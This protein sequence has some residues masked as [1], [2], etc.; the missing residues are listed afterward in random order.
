MMR[1][2][3]FGGTFNP[4]HHGHLR[5]ALEVKEGFPLDVCYLIPSAVPPHKRDQRV[6]SAADRMEMIRLAI[7]GFEGFTLCDVE[8]QRS[9]PSY[10]VDTVADLKNNLPEYTELFLMLGLDAFLEIDTWKQYRKLL[11]EIP[12]IVMIRPDTGADR[13]TDPTRRVAQYLHRHIS[14]DYKASLSPKRFTHH[15]LQTVFTCEVTL[16]D[17]SSSGIRH[18][19]RQN[20]SIRY[21]VPRSVQDYIREKG[22]YT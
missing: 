2:G 13:V 21:L 18:L 19:I 10:T 8:L 6:S 3:L 12:F 1:I 22:L 17:I 16:M 9:G 14:P 11:Q 5:A 20:R 4:I 15:R 7:D